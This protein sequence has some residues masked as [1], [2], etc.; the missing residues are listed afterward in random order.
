MDSEIADEL[1]E[2][3]ETLAALAVIVECQEF[4][5][6][7]KTIL[8]LEAEGVAEFTPAQ[9]ASI[10]EAIA[11]F[12]EDDGDLSADAQTALVAEKATLDELAVAIEVN[13]FKTKYALILTLDAENAGDFTDAQIA[14]IAEAIA[15]FGSDEGDLS[16]D[17]QSALVDQKAALEALQEAIDELDP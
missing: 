10:A 5:T 13:D 3:S 17:A 15:L 1:T 16:A 2:E 7:Y 11:L 8:A 9:K 6:K 14:S 12:G 4:V